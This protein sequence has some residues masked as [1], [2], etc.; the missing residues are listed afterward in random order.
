MRRNQA[1]DLTAI[2]ASAELVRTSANEVFGRIDVDGHCETLSLRSSSFRHW[3]TRRFYQQVRAVPSRAA[4]EEAIATLEAEAR[5]GGREAEVSLRVV[6]DADGI[7]IDL[8]NASWS[9]VRVTPQGWSVDESPNVLFR[10]GSSA[11][12]L[13]TP[14]RGGS[15]DD[16]RN[17]LGRMDDASWKLL[18][19]WML[20]AF[21]PDVPYPILV[22]HGEQGSAKSTTARVIKQLVDPSAAPL[23]QMPREPRELFIAAH[24]N[25]CLAYD[26]LSGL[27]PWVADALCQLSTGGGFASRRLYSDDEEVVLDVQRPIVLN[28]IDELTGRGDLLER[29][30]PIELKRMS[31][32]ARRSEREFWRA[33][34]QQ[35]P[36]LMACLMEVLVGV[37]R[38]HP[39]IAPAEL[40]RMAD[41]G[42]WGLATEHAL[43]WAPGSFVAAYRASQHDSQQIALESS[44]VVNPLR[45]LIRHGPYKGTA[46]E[47]IEALAGLAGG[48]AEHRNWPKSAAALSKELRRIQPQLRAEGIEV[49][50]DRD[51]TPERRRVIEIVHSPVQAVHLAPPGPKLDGTGQRVDSPAGRQPENRQAATVGLL[52]GLDSDHS[53]WRGEI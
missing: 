39:T 14:L 42:E 46:T 24:N 32:D 52:D 17:F 8:A 37:L 4:L 23:R 1:S 5:F 12:A 28:G 50:F 30:L 49:T 47:L 27:P 41:F 40:P 25:W 34:G 3:L 21:R 43:H 20:S 18:L 38:V 31:G 29:A 44:S 15:I 51:D 11:R 26:N 48:I 22:L 16:L 13:P 6:A 53:F 36:Y 2:A 9:A 33:F 7:W 35:A 10:R 19:T 45:Q